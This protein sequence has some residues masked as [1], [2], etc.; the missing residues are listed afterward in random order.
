MINKTLFPLLMTKPVKTLVLITSLLSSVLVTRA[1]LKLPVMSAVAADL[2]KVIG[3]YPNRFI[4]LMGEV[5]GEHPQSTD[6]QCNFKV[7]GAEQCTI[8][9][10]SAKKEVCSF[11]A[12]M[13]TTEDFEKAKQKFRGLYNQLNNLSADLGATQHVRFK[14]PYVSPDEKLKFTSIVFNPEPATDAALRLKVELVLQ[15]VEP[16]EWKVK[17]LVYDRE[18]EDAESGKR[19]EE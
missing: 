18:R 5:I 6:Y 3:D 8:T 14:A 12:L 19:I 10:Y 15:Y 16:M 11:E 1:Q 2:R 9:R 13:M 4:N 7:N 17:V